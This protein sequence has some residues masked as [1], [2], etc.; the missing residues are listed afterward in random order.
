[1]I[2]ASVP[3]LDPMLCAIPSGITQSNLQQHY[4]VISSTAQCAH[5]LITIPMILLEHGGNGEHEL[6]FCYMFPAA[7][8]SYHIASFS[9]LVVHERLFDMCLVV[10]SNIVYTKLF[11]QLFSFA[12]GN[13][14]AK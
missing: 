8:S 5:K 10:T 13:Y 3:V 7:T 4:R 6:L 1:M 11:L 9:V 2:A 12:Q 14:Y